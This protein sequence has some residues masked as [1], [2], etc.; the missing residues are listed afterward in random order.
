MLPSQE[1]S[2]AGSLTARFCG[3]FGRSV[4][5]IGQAARRLH[6]ATCKGRQ[7]RDAEPG[8]IQ[9]QNGQNPTPAVASCTLLG[10][11]GPGSL[12]QADRTSDGKGKRGSGSV[13]IGGR[14]NN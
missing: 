2:R 9:A 3:I 12:E 5:S 8:A 4:F 7:A 1:R 13:D 14:R 11:I 10:R 6:T